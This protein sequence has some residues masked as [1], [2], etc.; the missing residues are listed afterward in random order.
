MGKALLIGYKGC[1]P[2]VAMIWL[3]KY[4]LKRKEEVMNKMVIYNKISRII[5]ERSLYE[6]R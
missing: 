4:T 6:S 5:G 3:I 1:K 2:Y